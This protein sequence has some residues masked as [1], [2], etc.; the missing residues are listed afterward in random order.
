MNFDAYDAG[1]LS[2]SLVDAMVRLYGCRIL[3]EG[4]VVWGV[5]KYSETRPMPEIRVLFWWAAVA[6]VVVF[7]LSTGVLFQGVLPFIGGR[8]SIWAPSVVLFIGLFG[9]YALGYLVLLIGL[10]YGK[11]KCIDFV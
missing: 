9:C 8:S 10:Q 4:I 7:G 6:Y 1:A 2:P 5:L 3:G 11:E